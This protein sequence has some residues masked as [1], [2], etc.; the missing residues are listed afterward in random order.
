[1]KNSPFNYSG[2][3]SEIVTTFILYNSDL[4][5]LYRRICWTTLLHIVLQMGKSLCFF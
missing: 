4:Y 1:V 3:A 2:E 5:S